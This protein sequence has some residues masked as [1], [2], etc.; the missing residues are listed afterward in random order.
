MSVIAFPTWSCILD[1]AEQRLVHDY[2]ISHY[3]ALLLNERPG[4][5]RLKFDGPA[6]TARLVALDPY[7]LST[8]AEDCELASPE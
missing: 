6:G 8:P 5:R 2:I 1:C 3:Q 7:Y 4:P